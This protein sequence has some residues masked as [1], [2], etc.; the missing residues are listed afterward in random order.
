MFLD[1]VIAMAECGGA[2]SAH[3][4][5]HPGTAGGDISCQSAVSASSIVSSVW[6]GC[7]GGGGEACQQQLTWCPHNIM[8]HEEEGCKDTC[9]STKE[10]CVSH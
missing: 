6:P 10:L 5:Q 8:S 2:S 7:Q 1:L 3:N 9:V 4:G